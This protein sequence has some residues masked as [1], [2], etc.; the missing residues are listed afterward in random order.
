MIILSQKYSE[1]NNGIEKKGEFVRSI[2]LCSIAR[3]V[4]GIDSFFWL[5]FSFVS[6]YTV[7]ILTILYKQRSFLWITV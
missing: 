5:L 1:R 2:V 3:F 7:L 6:N 4:S